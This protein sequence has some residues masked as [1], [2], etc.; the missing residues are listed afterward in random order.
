MYRLGTVAAISQGEFSVS[1]VPLIGAFRQSTGFLRAVTGVILFFFLWLNIHPALA[2]AKDLAQAPAGVPS[3]SGR[4]QGEGA[5]S[6]DERL[7]SALKQVAVTL[8]DLD[9]TLSAKTPDLKALTAKKDQ[10]NFLRAALAEA[11]QEVMAGF[12]RDL[13]HIEKHKLPDVIKQ[14]HAKA[15]GDYQA[16]HKQMLGHL[17]ALAALNEPVGLKGKVKEA[18]AWLDQETA[19][20]TPKTFDPNNLP[21][22]VGKPLARKPKLTANELQQLLNPNLK[23][24]KASLEPTRIEARKTE[25]TPAELAQL[26]S[27]TSLEQYWSLVN[28]ASPS[29]GDVAA[30]AAGEGDSSFSV[31]P[32]QVGI[33]SS[34]SPEEPVFVAS[35]GTMTS[36]LAA[37]ALTPPGPEFLAPTDDVQITQA[38]RDL[39]AQLHN[40][41]VEIYNWVHNNIDFIPTYGSVQGSAL[42]LD[43]KAGNAFDIASLLIAL[44]RA[45]GTPARYAY[46][47]V[48][49]PAPDLM[50]WAGGFTVADAAQTFISTGGIPNAGLTSGGQTVAIRMEHVW[51]EAFVDF[52][53]SQGARNIKPD[54]WVPVDASFKQYAYTDGLNLQ[55]GVPFNAE[56]FLTAAQDGATVNEAE[57]W[58]QNLNQTNIQTRLTDY[59]QQLQTY[60]EQQNPDATVGE[61]LGGKTIVPET[62]PLLADTL[63]YKLIAKGGVYADLPQALRHQFRYSLFAGP[64]ERTLEDPIFSYQTGTPNLAG[65]KVTLSFVPSSDHDRETIESY[66]PQPHEDGSPIQPEEF[67]SSLPAYSIYVTPELRIEGQVVARGGSFT[68]GQELLGEGAFTQLYNLNDWDITTEAHVSGQASALGISL[69]GISTSQ[70]TTLKDR[71]ESTKTKL[72]ANNVTGL[73]GEHLSGDLLTATVWSYFATVESFGR[74]AQRQTMVDSPGLAYGFF[75][76]QVRPELR[77]G[78]VWRAHFPG[79]LMDIGHLRRV[80]ANKAGNTTDWVNYNRLRGQHFSAMEHAVPERFFDVPNDNQT[81]QGVSAVKALAVAASQ[82][83]KIYTLDYRN[84]SQL[85]NLQ[86]SAGVMDNVRAAIATGM[87]VTIH[88]R[89]ISFAGF[90]GAGYTIIDPQTGAGAY[91]IEGGANG[92][93]LS[94]PIV[95]ALVI[96]GLGTSFGTAISL[97]LAGAALVYII[98]ALTAL[99]FVVSTVVALSGPLDEVASDILLARMVPALGFLLLLELGVAAAAA[100]LIFSLISL[101]F[102][103]L[104]IATQL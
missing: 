30:I 103:M 85:A 16:R 54:R 15:A 91:L 37:S 90:N 93:L 25:A 19:D 71:L 49:I 42:T 11:N 44:Y 78:L 60:I 40:H 92:G 26:A 65:K 38:I 84:Q 20:K 5:P 29:R 72:E 75:H 99:A 53:P 45:A 98:P 17:D 66:L 101:H 63:P 2:A 83:Q 64:R 12:A 96:L 35:T 6:E 80:A 31:I 56:D 52:Y 73:T 41:P 8:A 69:Q 46:G 76:A 94:S 43:K 74:I 95:H 97:V 51:V 10:L 58:V 89:P 86:H 1:R 47:T 57:G 104:Y 9:K 22:Q 24:P 68:L 14:R 61:V 23:P 33:Q 82:G 100:P 28:L 32:A 55:S 87:E 13:A 79:V 21:F 102:L 36:L 67:P 3:P 27:V 7:N 81:P 88:E 18:K 34:F 62:D 50:N 39:A 70:L 77:Y 4:G 59:Q 48:Q